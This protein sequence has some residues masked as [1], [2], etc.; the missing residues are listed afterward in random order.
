VVTFTLQG[1]TIFE[2]GQG[3]QLLSVIFEAEAEAYRWL[4]ST[5]C[6]LEGII[7]AERLAMRARVFACRSDLE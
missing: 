2:Q 4:N 7:D 3:K 1:R 6:V 5:L